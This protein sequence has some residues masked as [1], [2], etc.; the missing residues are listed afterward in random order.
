MAQANS[1]ADQPLRIKKYPNRRYYDTTRSRH[2]TLEEIHQLIRD[3]RDVEVIDSR[4]GEDIT[5]KVLAQIL[6]ELDPL[7]LGVFP[8]AMLHRI[9]RSNEQIVTEF[10]DKYFNQALSAFLESK[11]TYEQFLRRSIGLDPAAAP[12]GDWMRMMM[13]PGLWPTQPAPAAAEGGDLQQTVEEL[14]R[15]VAELHSKLEARQQ[16]SARRKPRPRRKGG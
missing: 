3:G 11:K 13:M 16:R 10:V 4:T 6:I 5:A 14:R 1:D 12:G 15:Q 2:V 9:I 8:A 7:K